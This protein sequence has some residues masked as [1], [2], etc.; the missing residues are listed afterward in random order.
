METIKPMFTISQKKA[1]ILLLCIV[2]FIPEAAMAQTTLDTSINSAVQSA[3]TWIKILSALAFVSILVV[4]GITVYAKSTS[5]QPEPFMKAA[6][7]WFKG[8]IFLVIFFAVFGGL[9][10]LWDSTIK[11]STL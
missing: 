2:V 7:G 5:D 4:G 6:Y 10:L 11:S 3:W 8:L 9:K 1:M